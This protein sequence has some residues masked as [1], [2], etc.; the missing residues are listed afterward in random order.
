MKTLPSSYNRI[1]TDVYNS[2]KKQTESMCKEAVELLKEKVAKRGQK[3][4]TYL[5]F[6]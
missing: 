5:K 4:E 6:L 1:V 3:E 2:D